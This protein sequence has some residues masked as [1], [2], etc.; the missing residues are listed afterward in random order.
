MLHKFINTYSFLII[1][2]HEFI[3]KEKLIVLKVINTHLLTWLEC[4]AV[5]KNFRVLGWKRRRLTTGTMNNNTG[6]G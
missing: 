2:K 3:Y 4:F 1:R 6:H 5:Q